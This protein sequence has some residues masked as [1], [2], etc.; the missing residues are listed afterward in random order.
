MAGS[1]AAC[2][3]RLAA[4]GSPGTRF[5]STNVTSVTPTT[6]STETPIRRSTY[7]AS[8]CPAAAW[9]ARPSST[10]P[11]A[12]TWLRW[13]R[14]RPSRPGCTPAPVT[15]AAVTMFWRGCIS[16]MNGPEALSLLELLVQGVPLG[17]VA[18]RARLVGHCVD[19]RA[20][21]VRASRPLAD[22][23]PGS[24][25]EVVGGIRE[26]RPPV[27]KAHL[28][29]A[30]AVVVELGGDGGGGQVDR[31]AAASSWDCSCSASVW[32]L[33]PFTREV[34]RVGELGLLARHPLA[35]SADLAP[36]TSCFSASDAG[37]APRSATG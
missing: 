30:V 35:A 8:G 13:C 3:P 23:P 10:T 5:V 20:R 25:S 18:D 33:R 19:R 29:L 36:S 11:S 12:S 27:P 2:W 22:R 1:A 28:L 32:K 17:R 4:T 21:A 15:E 37:S 6:S 24:E 34:A 14:H 26:V 9:P 31:D 16:G 7:R